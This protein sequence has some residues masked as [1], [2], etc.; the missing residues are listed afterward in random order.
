VGSWFVYRYKLLAIISEFWV[1]SSTC[2][3]L[4]SRCPFCKVLFSIGQADIFTLAKLSS[5]S[6]F[7]AYRKRKLPAIS[8]VIDAALNVQMTMLPML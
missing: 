1:D 8:G 5:I 4:H 7:D 3:Y 2:S 6:S